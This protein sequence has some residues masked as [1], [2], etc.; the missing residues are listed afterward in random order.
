MIPEIWSPELWRTDSKTGKMR[1]RRLESEEKSS[2]EEPTTII[3]EEEPT[4]I[5][6]EVEPTTIVTEVEPTTIVTEV[7]PTTIVT[8]VEP[9]TYTLPPSTL[10]PVKEEESEIE[11][12]TSLVFS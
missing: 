7:E 1:K 3:T 2:E 5:A 12:D 4:T 6:T 11:E 8:E 10:L 9:P